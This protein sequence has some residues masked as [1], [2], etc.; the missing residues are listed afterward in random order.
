MHFQKSATCLTCSFWSTWH[1]VGPYS[2]WGLF[3]L[4]WNL[5]VHYNVVGCEF[6]FS[7]LLRIYWFSWIWGFHLSHEPFKYYCSPVLPLLSVCNSFQRWVGYSHTI[8]EASNLFLYLL[9]VLS[10]YCI[11]DEFKI[12]VSLAE[13]N[14]LFKPSSQILFYVIIFLFLKVSFLKNLFFLSLLFVCPSLLPPIFLVFWYLILFLWFNFFF[15]V[16]GFEAYL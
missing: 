2:L 10:L 9:Y 14:L 1:L 5:Q 11:L 4:F 12:V 3:F 6:Y 8:F 16:K 7:I 13:S 15:E